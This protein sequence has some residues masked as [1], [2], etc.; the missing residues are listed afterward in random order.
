MLPGNS[1]AVQLASSD[2]LVYSTL[3]SGVEIPHDHAKGVVIALA[4]NIIHDVQ[5]GSQLSNLHATKALSGS[6]MPVARM[7]PGDST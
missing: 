4:H 3:R 5:Q 1:L 2:E 6:Y 7:A